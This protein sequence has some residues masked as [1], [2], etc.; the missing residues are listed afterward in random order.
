MDHF[1]VTAEMMQATT[2]GK[3]L[4]DILDSLRAA[5]V[6][7][8]PVFAVLLVRHLRQDLELK[9]LAALSE[10]RTPLEVKV[11]VQSV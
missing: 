3:V 10:L 7:L 11:L 6:L 4:E 9:E 1:G 5:D 2:M 8:L